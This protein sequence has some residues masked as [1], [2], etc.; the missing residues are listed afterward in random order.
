MGTLTIHGGPVPMNESELKVIVCDK[1]L[2]GDTSVQLDANTRLLDA[3]IC[4]SLGLVQLA[5]EI[6]RRIP[7][8]TIRD[9][10]ITHDNFGSIGQILRFLQTKS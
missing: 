6:E 3:G 5:A 4:D 8:L 2:D 1:F 7:K 9:Q 10:E